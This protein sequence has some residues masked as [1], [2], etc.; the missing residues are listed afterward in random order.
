[1]R[2]GNAVKVLQERLGI[3]PSETIVFGDYLNDLSMADY[4]DHSFAPANAHPEVKNRFTDVI[5]SNAENG[6]TDKII[7]LLRNQE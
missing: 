4:A 5:K 1:M 2:E 6:V 7:E 3:L